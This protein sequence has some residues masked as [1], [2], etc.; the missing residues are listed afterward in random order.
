MS[1][2]RFRKGDQVRFRLGVRFVQGE[3][4]EDRGPI[5]VKG[6]RLYAVEFPVEPNSGAPSMIE[7][8]AEDLEL[9]QATAP[10]E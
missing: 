8:P 3:V 7:L 5:G 10:K 2:Q 4:T 6:R 1:E 9:V